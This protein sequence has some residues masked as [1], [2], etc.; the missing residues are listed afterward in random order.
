MGLN[1]RRLAK[2]AAWARYHPPGV[3]LDRRSRHVAVVP[4]LP[5]QRS[6]GPAVR[7]AK[8]PAA[9]CNGPPGAPVRD[10]L[11]VLPFSGPAARHR[12]VLGVRMVVRTALF[13]ERAKVK[14]SAYFLVVGGTGI[15]PVTPAV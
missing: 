8:C 15:E 3:G 1:C 14:E 11:S 6:Y 9:A 5:K 13:C 10:A 7:T 12:A 2:L 4:A